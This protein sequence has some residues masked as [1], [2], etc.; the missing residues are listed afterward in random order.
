MTLRGHPV[1]MAYA[2]SYFEA[3]YVA[4]NRMIPCSQSA[5]EMSASL[6]SAPSTT[7]ILWEQVQHAIVSKKTFR[8]RKGQL[9]LSRDVLSAYT[10]SE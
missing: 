10:Q 9:V 6:K 2:A 1:F 4:M 8:G 5:T 3:N 7:R